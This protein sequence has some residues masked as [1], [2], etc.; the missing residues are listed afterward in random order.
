MKTNKIIIFSFLDKYFKF[1]F[2]VIKIII[3]LIKEEIISVKRFNWF[4]LFLFENKKEN[5]K[6][7][8]QRTNKQKDLYIYIN[9]KKLKLP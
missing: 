7:Y 5:F 4:G 8:Q 9:R 1:L 2:L 6:Y 3:I